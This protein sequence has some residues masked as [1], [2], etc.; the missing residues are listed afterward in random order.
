MHKKEMEVHWMKHRQSR[1]Q[2]AQKEK[3]TQ[4]VKNCI[5]S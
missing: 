3:K 5:K 4:N 1:A 2:E